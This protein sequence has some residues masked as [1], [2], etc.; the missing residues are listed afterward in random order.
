MARSRSVLNWCFRAI[1]REDPALRRFR[2]LQETR[3]GPAKP[4]VPVF[5][6]K[7]GLA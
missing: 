3:Q 5:A 7:S 4:A 6:P 1:W 2:S